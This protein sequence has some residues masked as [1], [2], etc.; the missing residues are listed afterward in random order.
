MYAGTV[1]CINDGLTFTVAQQGGVKVD[2]GANKNLV[3]VG[4]V[5]TGFETVINTG[6]YIELLSGS[7]ILPGNVVN[8]SRLTLKG[9]TTL[10]I[11]GSQ[12]FLRSYRQFG[13][14]TQLYGGSTLK[15]APTKFVEIRG[16]KF[17]TIDNGTTADA[18]IKTSV[19]EVSGGE[20]V[21]GGGTAI[22]RFATLDVVGDVR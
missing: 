5:N 7:A 10:E 17:S 19:L 14:V 22:H 9:D 4:T 2:P 3:I 13:G 11:L 21:L 15:T 1:A 12:G 16:G 6:G 20:I 8:M 18:T